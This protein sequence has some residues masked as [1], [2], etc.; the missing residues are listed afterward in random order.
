[1]NTEKFSLI[2]K[3]NSIESFLQRNEIKLGEKLP[4]K[5]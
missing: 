1:M 2:E 4:I 3:A 5:L